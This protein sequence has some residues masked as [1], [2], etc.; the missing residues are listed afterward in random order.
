MHQAAALVQPWLSGHVYSIE[1]EEE[2][3]V[4]AEA[5][6]REAKLKAQIDHLRGVV[7]KLSESHHVQVATKNKNTMTDA[8]CPQTPGEESL[9]T[10]E[11][12]GMA[13]ILN[14]AEQLRREGETKFSL[15]FPSGLDTPSEREL[16]PRKVPGLVLGEEES[17]TAA[18][19][20][21]DYQQKDTSNVNTNDQDDLLARTAEKEQ[22]EADLA[23]ERQ[24]LAAEAAMHDTDT[25]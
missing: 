22:I 17:T 11:E 18:P 9:E 25:D 2:R 7:N 10:E 14:K 3:R 16:F 20:V 1:N 19:S 13:E 5:V 6:S 23:L 8:E 12:R 15:G 4:N 24:L 21:Q